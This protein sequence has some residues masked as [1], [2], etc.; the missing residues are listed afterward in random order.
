MD[1][2]RARAAETCLGFSAVLVREEHDEFRPMEPVRIR[3]EIFES[4]TH[5]ALEVS[6]RFPTTCEQMFVGVG[7]YIIYFPDLFTQRKAAQIIPS[8]YPPV[9]NRQKSGWRNRGFCWDLQ[10]KDGLKWNRKFV[11]RE[12]DATCVSW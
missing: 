8:P 12:W 1:D 2:G 5:N 3:V 11:R 7:W 9:R 10:F 6:Q 4:I